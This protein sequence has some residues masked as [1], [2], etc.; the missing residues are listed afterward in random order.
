MTIGS[1]PLDIWE[2]AHPFLNVSITPLATSSSIQLV[3]QVFQAPELRQS[4]LIG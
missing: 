1:L 2:L 3:S 4:R